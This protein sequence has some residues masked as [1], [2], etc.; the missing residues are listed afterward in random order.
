[1]DAERTF[2]VI[3]NL[4][5][6][7][8]IENALANGGL[9]EARTKLS[10]VYDKIDSDGTDDFSGNNGTGQIEYTPQTEDGYLGLEKP[11]G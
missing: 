5:V 6:A 3:D 10:K 2:N 1:V 11:L 9:F 8:A 7:D 4:I